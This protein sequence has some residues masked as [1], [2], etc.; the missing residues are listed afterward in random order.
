VQSNYTNTKLKSR[1]RGASYTIWPG[2]GVGLFYIGTPPTHTAGATD[3]ANSNQATYTSTVQNLNTLKLTQ[4]L[5]LSLNRL[6]SHLT[7]LT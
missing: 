6:T 2:N 3:R 1:F 4:Q 7:S 5:D